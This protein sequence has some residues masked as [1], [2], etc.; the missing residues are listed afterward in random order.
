MANPKPISEVRIGRVKAAIWP[1][2]T[3][4]CTRHNGRACRASVSTTCCCLPKWPIRPTRASS[5][6]SR[7]KSRRR[8][9]S[10]ARIRERRGQSPPLPDPS[11]TRMDTPGTS[12]HD[13][14]PVVFS[15][16][17]LRKP[18]ASSWPPASLC[19]ENQVRFSSSVGN[20]PG[21]EQIKQRLSTH[22]FRVGENRSCP[23]AEIRMAGV[24][25]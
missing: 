10:T 9:P 11:T 4:G 25:S 5:S 18:S 6:F 16:T 3:K 2:G 21:P 17:A 8:R 15:D 13:F 23:S 19:P 14:H 20:R 22:G 1:N 24:S 7:K 12:Q